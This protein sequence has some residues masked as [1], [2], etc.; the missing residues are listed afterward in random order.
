[1]NGF[2][3]VVRHRHPNQRVHL[4]ADVN[5]FFQVRKLISDN[6]LANRRSTVDVAGGWVGNRRTR[7]FADVNICVEQ[8]A[9][10]LNQHFCRERS[11]F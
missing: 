1:M 11:F 3:L 8:Y 6:R 9:A 10:H 4:I 5:E 2:E 7:Y